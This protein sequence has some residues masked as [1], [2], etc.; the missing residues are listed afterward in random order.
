MQ[1]NYKENHLKPY[2][3]KSVNSKGRIYKELEKSIRSPYQRDRD[4]II[5]S[6]SFRRLKH[7]TQVFV[8]SEGDH[9]RTRLTHS[10]EV[11]QIART[12][13]R[14]LGLN[15][16]LSE[17]LS[18]SHDLGHTPFGHAGEEILSECMH[19]YGGFDHNIQTLR[20]VMLLENKYYK[21]QGL[22]LT[23]ETLDGLIKHNGP[24]KKISKYKKIFRKNIFKNK[25]TF[26]KYPSLEAQIASIS[27]DI[28]YN[29]HDL[30]D[31]LRAGLFKLKF[32]SSIPEISKIVKKH[33]KNT[34]NFRKEIIINQIVRELINLMVTD[35]INTT[36]KNLT[37][38]SP[39]SIIDIYNYPGLIVDF[40]KK[41]KLIDSKIKTFLKYNM[42][43][44]K[45]VLTNT[46][47]GKIIIKDLF[48]YLL[49]YPKKHIKT[50]LFK[51]ENKE[52]V[53]ADFI[54]GMTDRYAINLYKQI[55]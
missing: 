8:N 49:K 3:V 21:F 2:A 53:I 33:L 28:A 40:S 9:Y 48:K 39:R 6:S 15:E 25:I 42:Y 24:V 12:L 52:R 16:D 36:K 4:R 17:T 1:K 19:N 13:A 51:N 45:K 37:Q 23:I 10:M 18:L 38:N 35:V 44:H 5:H 32:F 7:K 29:N 14:A 46:N 22:N 26:N 20:I 47:K 11:S 30:E 41:M 54:A 31:G 50:E 43:N 34:K 27:D 55:K